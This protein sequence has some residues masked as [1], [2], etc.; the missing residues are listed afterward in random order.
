MDGG[1]GVVPAHRVVI[2]AVSDKL[3]ALCKEGGRVV[4]RNINFKLLQQVV[5]FIYTGKLVLGSNA[6]FEDL[7]DGMDLLKINIEIENDASV[8]TDDDDVANNID[9][10]NMDQNVNLGM[11]DSFKLPSL[12][13]E[14]WTEKTENIKLEISNIAESYQDTSTAASDTTNDASD[15]EN[16][17]SFTKILDS[18]STAKV[19]IKEVAKMSPGK[20]VP[21]P[22]FETKNIQKRAI[23]CEYCGEM[24]PYKNYMRHCMINHPDSPWN[25]RKFCGTCKSSVPVVSYNHHLELFGHDDAS[26]DS[27]VKS[28]DIEAMSSEVK[29]VRKVAKSQT[30]IPCDYCEESVTLASYISHCKKL[31]S[32]SDSDERCR[33][34]CFKCGVNVHIVAEKFHHEIYHPAKPRQATGKPEPL[35]IVEH[36]KS[37]TKVPCDFCS[38]SVVFCHFK[39][40][41]K[42]RHPEI[43]INEV[44]KCTK[45]GVKLP[46][47]SFE[48]HRQIFHKWSKVQP[49]P[50]SSSSPKA[51]SS[52]I[53]KFPQ[54][55]TPCTYCGTRIRP[56]QMLL[57]ME[58]VHRNKVDI[59]QRE[60][61][62]TI[63]VSCPGEDVMERDQ[64]DRNIR[65]RVSDM[66]SELENI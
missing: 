52:P 9:E 59:A 17:T 32:I 45:C 50:I 66:S 38:D 16:G 4:V 53:M 43:A 56:G 33:R 48:F 20:K 40:H 58:K 27:E 23:S 12:S 51:T 30:K 22:R 2:S 24:I 7:R 63:P 13:T 39:S 46:K 29:E 28:D 47:V 44:V 8:F 36:N 42:A 37:L 41:V 15:E 1:V 35:H 34:K 14:F 54:A 11:E 31:H 25:K 60:E 26:G 18:F 49:Q 5:K 6:D 62:I 19:S 61:N 64:D 3:A 10:T 21:R 65:G 55:K 57:H